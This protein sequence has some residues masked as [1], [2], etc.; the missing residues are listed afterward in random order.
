MRVP[1]CGQGEE[2]WTESEEGWSGGKAVSVDMAEEGCGSCGSGSGSTRGGTEN[3]SGGPLSSPLTG[4]K[5]RQF[6]QRARTAGNGCVFKW[7]FLQPSEECESPL[8]GVSFSPASGHVTCFSNK[9]AELTSGIS[10][11]RMGRYIWQ[12]VSLECN[13]NFSSFQSCLRGDCCVR[14]ILELIA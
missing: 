8:C 2:T 12:A 7:C 5:K 11:V 13:M 14:V 9:L 3:G 1:H 4:Q 10:T 6:R